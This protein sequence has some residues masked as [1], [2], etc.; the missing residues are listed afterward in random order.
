MVK[1][2]HLAL[3]LALPP[4]RI[5]TVNHADDIALQETQFVLILRCVREKRDH[6]ICSR[7]KNSLFSLAFFNC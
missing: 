7:R 5:F 4:G 6:L 3:G 1:M 2:V